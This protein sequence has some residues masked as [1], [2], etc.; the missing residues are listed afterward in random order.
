MLEVEDFGTWLIMLCKWA[1]KFSCVELVQNLISRDPEAFPGIQVVPAF[2]GFPP[3][4]PFV[5]DPNRKIF[6]RMDPLERLT[7]GAPMTIALFSDV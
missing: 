4:A 5:S 3:T 2:V 6:Y 1:Y 7:S